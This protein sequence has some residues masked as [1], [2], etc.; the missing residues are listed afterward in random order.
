MMRDHFAAMPP[1]PRSAAPALPSA[2]SGRRVGSIRSSR[3]RRTSAAV[4]SAF[5]S[6][7]SM[8]SA[9]FASTGIGAGSASRIEQARADART[10]IASANRVNPATRSNSAARA[11]PAQPARVSQ[12][13]A[14]QNAENAA[15]TSTPIAPCPTQ[16]V[17]KFRPRG[18]DMLRGVD[19]TM[20]PVEW[21]SERPSYRRGSAF[22]G[23]LDGSARDDRH[24]RGRH[25]R[26]ESAAALLAARGVGDVTVV[27]AAAATGWQDCAKSPGG[28]CR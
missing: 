26:A 13:L 9:E 16:R 15:T 27:E 18:F 6:G 10:R 7:R 14:R 12:K 8:R 3:R 24:Y 28:R 23:T 17:R 5:R 4:S 11:S 20:C 21:T 2:Q 22:I 19:E 25:W 1:L